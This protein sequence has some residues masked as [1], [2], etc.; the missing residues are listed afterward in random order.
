MPVTA[1]KYLK[2]CL[3]NVF[4]QHAKSR[5]DGQDAD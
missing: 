2:V 3:Q 5:H 1:K 4:M